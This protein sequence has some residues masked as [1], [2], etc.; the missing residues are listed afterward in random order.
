MEKKL[1][2]IFISG[3]LFAS[4]SVFSGSTEQPVNNSEIDYMMINTSELQEIQN[5]KEITMIN[6]HIPWE[7]NI[8]GTDMELPYDEIEKYADALPQDKNEKIIIYCRSDSMG[9]QAAAT[10]IEMGYTD[11]SNL[12][13]GYIAWKNTGLAFE[14]KP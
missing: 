11:V 8:P 7:G 2:A 1:L 5:S 10:L 4:C 13:G 14:E 6:V 12:E 9:H 3:I